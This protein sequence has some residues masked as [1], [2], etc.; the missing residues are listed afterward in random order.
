MASAE[1]EARTRAN[2]ERFLLEIIAEYKA[3]VQD[4]ELGCKL[5]KGFFERKER[6]QILQRYRARL[7]RAEKKLFGIRQMRLNWGGA[8]PAK[9]HK[10]EML[11]R[12]IAPDDE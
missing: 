3:K 6:V 7:A 5:A 11:S 9:V 2:I 8:N 12:S 1:V 10:R 4:A